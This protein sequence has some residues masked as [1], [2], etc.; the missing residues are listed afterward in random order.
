MLIYSLFKQ[1]FV[2]FCVYFSHV[3]V[4]GCDAKNHCVFVQT[5]Q[6]NLITGRYITKTA[7]GASELLAVMESSTQPS[8]TSIDYLRWESLSLSTSG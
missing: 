4:H 3:S 7:R 5:I 8:S 1:S 6:I 2:S